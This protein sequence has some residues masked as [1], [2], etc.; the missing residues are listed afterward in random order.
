MEEEHAVPVR[1]S[2]DPCTGV[3]TGVAQSDSAMAPTGL[4]VIT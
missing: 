4:Q 2:N 1:L 3:S